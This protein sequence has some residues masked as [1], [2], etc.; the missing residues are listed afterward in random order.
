MK[1]NSMIY[2]RFILT[3]VFIF[4]LGMSGIIMIEQKVFLQSIEFI[5]TLFLLLIG[6]C[7]FLNCSS[8]QI[9][10]ITLLWSLIYAA[11][12]AIFFTCSIGYH[13]MGC[14][15]PFKLYILPALLSP[16]NFLIL[17]LLNRIAGIKPKTAS[18]NKL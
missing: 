17:F 18:K 8:L 6:V 15:S 4:L 7:V 5:N 3:F 2:I 12:I 10:W 13:L 14:K 1:G 9:R 16:M 11:S